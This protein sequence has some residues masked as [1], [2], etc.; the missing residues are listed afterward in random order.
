MK[1]KILYICIFIFTVLIVYFSY[2]NTFEPF[3][4][5]R[6]EIQKQGWNI[7]G[8]NMNGNLICR[9]N[10][11]QFV[12]DTGYKESN[13]ICCENGKYNSEG[14]CCDYGLV[15]DGNGNCVVA[16]SVY[17]RYSQNPNTKYYQ[18]ISKTMDSEYHKTEDQLLLE[19][20]PTDV[21]FGNTFV[22]DEKGKKISYPFSS[23][24]GSITYYTPG[25]YPL[26]TANYVPSYEDSIYLSKLT[27]LSTTT[28]VYNKAKMQG[29][30]CDYFDNQ[31]QQR[32]TVCNQ[33]E[34][35]ECASTKCCVL[36]GGSKCVTGDKTGA[37]FKKNYGD[38]FVK[39]KD[40][41]Y[42]Q[43]LCYGNCQ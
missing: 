17:K 35:T 34:P 5:N 33:L 15:N 22:Y 18:D 20:E 26:G 38:V 16:Q 25:S 40:F 27:G 32:E 39:N 19:A 12:C 21:Q 13:G 29:G 9:N 3:I 30:F 43:G 31:P 24:Q 41:Y 14:V 28:P 11:C 6:S 2:N 4:A 37:T 8:N 7:N 1:Q 42:Y 36:L 10:V 23:V